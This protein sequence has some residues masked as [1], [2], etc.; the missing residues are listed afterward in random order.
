MPVSVT[1]IQKCYQ[2]HLINY[3]TNQLSIYMRQSPSF[4]RS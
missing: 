3:T 2:V 4:F 1:R